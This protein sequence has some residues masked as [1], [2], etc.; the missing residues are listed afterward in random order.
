MSIALGIAAIAIDCIGKK[1][2]GA[3]AGGTARALQARHEGAPA[4][5][6]QSMKEQAAANVPVADNRV[7]IGL[8]M[9]VASGISLAVSSAR[10]EPGRR[11]VPVV[12]LIAYTL[13]FCMMV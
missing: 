11:S 13:L 9:A 12:I 5:V 2:A 10:G 6:I 8:L 3:A 1:A 7:M 4:E